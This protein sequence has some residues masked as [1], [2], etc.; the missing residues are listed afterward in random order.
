MLYEERGNMT[1]IVEVKIGEE[2]EEQ[3]SCSPWFFIG[4]MVCILEAA[5][6]YIL[7]VRNPYA[8]YPRFRAMFAMNIGVAFIITI[9]AYTK[10]IKARPW[11]KRF[12]LGF[13]TMS[14]VALTILT[15]LL[16]RK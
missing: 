16:L 6:I 11:T 2:Y 7:S 14:P 8:D 9:G 1:E 13:A 4:W 10:L 12:F 15:I 5:A 3:F